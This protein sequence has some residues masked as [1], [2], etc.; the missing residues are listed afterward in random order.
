MKP[1]VPCSTFKNDATLTLIE[2]SSTSVYPQSF[3]SNIDKALQLCTGIVGIMTF[4]EELQKENGSLWVIQH[5]RKV[6]SRS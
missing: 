3:Y 1:F 5:Q 4:L 6:T 2:I